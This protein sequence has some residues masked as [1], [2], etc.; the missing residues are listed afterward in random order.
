MQP[1]GTQREQGR[2]DVATRLRLITLETPDGRLDFGGSVACV[3]TDPTTRPYAAEAIARAVIGPRRREVDGTIEIAGRFVALQSLPAPLLSPSAPATVDDALF[4][5]MWRATSAQQRADLEAAHAQ[6]RL[7]RHRTDAA[8]ERAR[9]RANALTA[10]ATSAPPEPQTVATPTVD[11]PAPAPAPVDTVTPV[12]T[13]MLEALDGL[14]PVPSPAAHALADAFDELAA[15][16][17]PP[18]AVVPADVDLVAAEQRVDGARLALAGVA[19]GM[20]PQARARIETCHR[21]VVE[22]ERMLFEAGK[23]DR[24]EALAQYQGALAD[25]RAALSDAGVDSYASFL[26]TTAAGVAPVD[27][28]VRL[29]AELDLAHA[30]AE[31]GLARDAVDGTSARLHEE[32]EV[33]LRA[34]AAQLLGRFP[35]ADPAAE[36]RALRVEHPDAIATHDALQQVLTQAGEAPSSDVVEQAREF[37]RR[38]AEQPV[39]TP[40]APA[41]VSEPEPAPAR[42]PAPTRA[43][44]LAKEQ[45]ALEVELHA[46]LDER[47]AHEQALAALEARLEAMD[48]LR[49]PAMHQLDVDT[50]LALV[51]VMLDRYRSADLLAGRLPLV[52]DGPFDALDPRVVTLIAHQLATATDVQTIVVTGERSVASAFATVGARAVVWPLTGAGPTYETSAPRIPASHPSAAFVRKYDLSI[53]AMCGLHPDKVV[54]AECAHCGRGSCV[55]CLVYVPGETDLWCVGCAEALRSRNLKLLRRRGA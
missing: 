47:A 20:L 50:V 28:E 52:L 38:R 41:P 39:L 43:D 37:V 21:A 11:L 2:P 55:D 18:P 36:L 34:R 29:R 14:G 54:A 3:A 17:P 33:E 44:D 9:G 12:V 27:L 4:D 48:E 30:E 25:E 32:R 49:T 26:V 40:V 1:G 5:E 51:G 7:E 8:I 24:L 45:R 6:R 16:A 42:L 46:L 23:K 22:T 35:G 10:R 13:A 15:S 19:G 31:L 53:P